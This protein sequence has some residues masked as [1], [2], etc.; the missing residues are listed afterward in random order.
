MARPLRLN[1]DGTLHVYETGRDGVQQACIEFLR[2]Q[3]P[4]WHVYR[5]QSG[6]F[7]SPDGR[8]RYRIGE[9]GKTDLLAFRRVRTH[10]PTPFPL[11]RTLL[12]EVKCNGGEG[13]LSREQE[14]ERD[15]LI[16][17]GLE[18]LLV[19]SVDVLKEYLAR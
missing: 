7:L 10:R 1:S 5:I 6:V 8:R 14:A 9:K 17:D 13:R 12:I 18:W 3:R 19:D 4:K 16:E 2:A 15:R 11:T